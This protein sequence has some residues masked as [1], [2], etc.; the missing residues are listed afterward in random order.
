M[1]YSKAALEFVGLVLFNGVRTT[2]REKNTT[3]KSDSRFD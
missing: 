2:G 1:V 3:E